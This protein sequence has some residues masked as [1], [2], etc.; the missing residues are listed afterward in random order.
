[1]REIENHIAQFIKMQFPSFTREE[2]TDFITFVQ[3]YY[4]WMESNGQTLQHSRDL[5]DYRDVD[6]TIDSFVVHF[7]EKYLRNLP[8]DV[9]SDKRQLV[10]HIQDLYRSKGTE[11]GTQLLFRLLY[12]ADVNL[13]YPGE[14]VFKLSNGEWKVPE[15]IEVSPSAVNNRFIGKNIFGTTSKATAF[16]ERIVRRRVAG[17]FVDTL[18]ITARTGDFAYNERIV[19]VDD[20]TIEGS[21]KVIGSLSDLIVTN[22]GQ[23]FNVGDVLNVT[24][25]SG[26]QGKA[27]VTS[28]STETGRVNFKIFNGGFGY[29]TNSEVI[30]SERNLVAVNFT[31]T[32]TAISGF[33][34]FETIVQP[35]LTIEFTSS[36]A[37]TFT[38]GLVIENYYGNGSLSANGLIV[39]NNITNSTS[40]TIT[41]APG[42]G[43][44]ASDATISLSGNTQ[45]AVITNVV[46]S[47]ATGN[48]MFVSNSSLGVF[49]LTND[50]VDYPGNYIYGLTSNT[51]ANVSVRSTG[52]AATFQIGGLTNEEVVLVFSDRLGG[53]NTGNVAFMDIKIDG[54]NS[55]VA[56]NGYGFEKYPAGDFNT[57]LQDV[58]RY[59]NKTIGEISVLTSINPGEGYNADPYVLVIEPEVA[60]LNKRDFT[61]KMSNLNGFFVPGE[62]IEM[63]ANSIGQ[64][65]NITGFSGL[66]AN[67]V[68]TS[69]P[70]IGEFVWQSNGTANTATGYIFQSS[71]AGGSGTIKVSNT[72]G[73]FDTS[74]VIVTSTTN[75]TATV[76]SSSNVT[77]TTLAAGSVKTSN[78][79]VLK[80]KRLSLYNDFI[81][82]LT[83]LGKTSGA[84]A[85]ISDVAEDDSVPPIGENAVISANVQV[86]NTVVSTLKVIDSGFGYVED[87]TVTLSTPTS[88]QI[89][90]ARV[91]LTKQGQ[92]EGYYDNQHGFLDSSSKIYDGDYYQDYSYELQTRIPLS[93][94]SEALKTISHTA[95]TKFFGKVVVDSVANDEFQ[96][97]TNVIQNDRTTNLDIVNVNGDFKVGDNVRTSTANGVISGRSTVFVIANNNP[98]IEINTTAVA[99]VS[100]NGIVKTIISN[101]THSTIYTLPSTGGV[102]NTGLYNNVQMVIGRNVSIA[103]V[104]QG[105]TVTGSFQVG[106]LVYQSNTFA[107]AQTANGIVTSANN[108]TVT[109]RSVKGNWNSNSVIFGSTSNAYANVVSV[110][111]NTA[112]FVATSAINTL[113]LSNTSGKFTAGSISGANSTADTATIEYVKIGIDT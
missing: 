33:Q 104:N 45:S 91:V 29:T 13:Y 19:L 95:G 102:G 106:E 14:D 99:G 82:G 22:G 89:V 55:N 94:Y 73:I 32:N 23:D 47:T 111:N 36:N 31:N 46:D 100:F 26:K 9:V 84:T 20:P 103:N 6:R 63:T 25:G 109:I 51:Y 40:G 65:L 48:V 80:V 92:S 8:F 39:S 43:N 3:A 62:T 7:K 41:V 67:G 83:I 93:K 18:Y 77:L 53:K 12:N 86:A 90:T 17:K 10:K 5:F 2:S 37:Y 101:T 79:T 110:A 16:C 85:V 4:E 54:S 27:L 112:T 78:T 74:N 1:M 56:S 68:V 76:T 21:P 69:A 35:L 11:R 49:N 61:I 108:T 98:F 113:Y 71:V 60:S 42:F 58:L 59:G 75:A 38:S 107:G 87:E 34:Q 15:Y 97:I 24:T 105:N 66:A 57:T 81:D 28:V 30:I 72:T 64:Q 96:F 50:F 44:V 52:T 88:P 70:E